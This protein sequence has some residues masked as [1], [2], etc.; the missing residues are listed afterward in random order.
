[1][2]KEKEQ[3]MEWEMD[4]YPDKNLAQAYI[5]FQA[6]DEQYN[7]QEALEKGTLFPELYRP[8]KKKR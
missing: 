1:M 2:S 4:Y 5:P 7:P 8:Y 6:Y 3:E